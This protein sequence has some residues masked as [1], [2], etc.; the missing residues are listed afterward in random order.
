MSRLAV[1]TGGT[2]GIGA[3]VALDLKD[4]G[5]TVIVTHHSPSSEAEDFADRNGFSSYCWDVSNYDECLSGI[6]IIKQKHGNPEIL[7]NNA[8]ITRDRRMHK[9]SEV[10]WTQVIQTNL[11]S[12]FNMTRSVIDSMRDNKFGRIINISSINAKKGQIG[13]TNYCASKAGIIGFT[14]AFAL[15][16]ASYGITVN[17]VAPGYIDTDMVRSVPSEILEKIIAEIPVGRLGQPNEVAKLVSFLAAE[18]SG[19]ITGSTFNINGGQFLG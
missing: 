4:Q 9:M 16:C 11:N 14:K 15:E 6:E 1:V 13:Q 5:H 12:C 8:G 2:R 19:F 18:H 10:D 3:A 17:A 7:V